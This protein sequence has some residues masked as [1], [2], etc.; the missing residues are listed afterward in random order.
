MG[1]GTN[2]KQQYVPYWKW[3]CYKSGMWSR[4]SKEDEAIMLKKAI[5]FTS[6]HIDYG[7]AMRDVVFKWKY[8]MINF[9]TNK[10]INRKAY[11]GHCAVFYKLQIPEYIVRMAWKK[12]TDNQRILANL[13]A[14]KTIKLW[15]AKQLEKSTNTLKIG[16]GDVTKMGFQMK[17]QLN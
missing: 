6:N 4:V 7:D 12:L 1:R 13:E 10:S 11:L 5:D 3:E 8:S 9:L 15:E 14:E 16:K 2:L 17:L